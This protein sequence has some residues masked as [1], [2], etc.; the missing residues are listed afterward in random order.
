MEK[1]SQLVQEVL[2]EHFLKNFAFLAENG[3]M[4]GAEVREFP[5]FWRINSG[6]NDEQFNGIFPKH[7]SPISDDEIKAQIDFFEKK[8]LSFS[9]WAFDDFN[10]LLKNSPFKLEKMMGVACH[11]DE[12]RFP[13]SIS[14]QVSVKRVSSV[15]EIR[16]W[17]N[18]QLSVFDYQKNA[19]SFLTHLLSSTLKKS[20]DIAFFLG[21]LNGKPVGSAWV[22]LSTHSNGCKVA[23]LWGGSVLPEARKKGVATT[24]AIER[25]K[26]AKEQNAHYVAT[27][28][29]PD[30]MARGYFEKLGFQDACAF[31]PYVYHF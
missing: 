23:G 10:S 24:L 29:M 30:E 17:V 11:M 5:H 4:E 28:L 9:W 21:Y 15:L 19:E 8:S 20:E 22:M 26:Y 16:D 12:V 2:S 14:S 31:F 6:I 7:S 27:L 1:P 25:I 3:G 13:S 18:I